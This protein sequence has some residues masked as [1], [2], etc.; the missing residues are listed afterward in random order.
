[1]TNG[2]IE[3]YQHDKEDAKPVKDVQEFPEPLRMDP[4]CAYQRRWRATH[5]GTQMSKEI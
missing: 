1:M 2:M 4:K 5:P 3:F